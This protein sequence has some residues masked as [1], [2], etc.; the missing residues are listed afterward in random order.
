MKITS[1]YYKKTERGICILRCRSLDTAVV[2][3]E[4]IEG[5]PVTELG[6]YVCSET[7]RTLENGVWDCGK[8]P[9][10]LPGLWGNRLTELSLPLSVRKIGRYAFYNWKTGAVRGTKHWTGSGVFTG[11]RESAKGVWEGTGEKSCFWRSFQNFPRLCGCITTENRRQGF[12]FQNFLRN[13]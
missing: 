1:F 7:C 6:D 4:E 8:E 2:I 5:L 13:P 11:C 9:E 12:C 3:P 10:D